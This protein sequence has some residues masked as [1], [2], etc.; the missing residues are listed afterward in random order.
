MRIALTLSILFLF[1]FKSNSQEANPELSKGSINT[2]EITWESDFEAALA[3]AK[4]NNKLLFVECYSP[5]SGLSKSR[6]TFQKYRSCEK[7]Q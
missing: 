1:G 6:A 7:V 5:T 3:K 4:A 2:Q